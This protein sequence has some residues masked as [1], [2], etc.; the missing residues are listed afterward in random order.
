MKCNK[1]ILEIFFLIILI[2]F[3]LN[4]CSNNQENDFKKEKIGQELNFLDSKIINI[5]N[6]LNN[7][8]LSNYTITSEEISLEKQNSASTGNSS[9]SGGESSSNE[10]NK[11]SS[12]EQSKEESNNVTVTQM[13]QESQLGL[14]ENDINW[15]KIKNDIEVINESSSIIILDLSSLNIDNSEI[16]SFS[17]TLN[18]T[19]L[20]I[21][22][23]NRI[24]SLNNL[25]KL[26][27][28]IPRFNR[29]IGREDRNQNIL[30]TKSYLVNAYSLVEQGDWTEIANSLNNCDNSFRNVMNNIEYLKNKE[31]KVNKTYILIKEL[32]N[33]ISYKDKKLFYLKYRNLIESLN[34]L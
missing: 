3:A 20:S 10:N 11:S 26:Y 32:Q 29:S 12:Q 18:N 22:E 31:Y 33:S 23:E 4:G 15:D 1:K 21:K 24:T 27:S 5:I 19:I 30:D 34:N 6:D 17:S 16:L 13:Q 2:L 14:N 8:S 7:I 9:Q 28:Y 25:A